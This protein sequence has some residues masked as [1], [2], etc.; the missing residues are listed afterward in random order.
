[1]EGWQDRKARQE[2]IRLATELAVRKLRQR[3]MPPSTARLYQ[4]EVLKLR[5]I[6][7]EIFSVELSVRQRN[8]SDQESDDA[9]DRMSGE[10]VTNSE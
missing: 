3:R 1:M 6:V 5:Q 2:F 8:R 10:R 7:Q 4:L 9:S